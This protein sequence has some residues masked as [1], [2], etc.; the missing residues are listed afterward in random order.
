MLYD[1]LDNLKRYMGLSPNLD[2]AI[3]FLQSHNLS[4][5]PMGRTEVDGDHVFVNVMEATA[6][7]GEGR[8][9][10]TH[11][12]YMDL[13]IDLEGAELCEVPLGEVRE[14]VPYDPERDIAMWD[15]DATGTVALGAGRF[16]LFF[17]GEPHKPGILTGRDAHLK[18]AVFKI[19]G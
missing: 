1:T 4:A 8:S 7:P 15:G 12:R 14:A 9:F 17:V 19:E 18:K 16:A 2:K 11:A 5:L 3:A 10:E 6:S 13:Q